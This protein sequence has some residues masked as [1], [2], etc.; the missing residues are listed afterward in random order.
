[1]TL[2]CVYFPYLDCKIPDWIL[3]LCNTTGRHGIQ[4]IPCHDTNIIQTGCAVIMPQGNNKNVQYIVYI[5]NPH[6]FGAITKVNRNVD[7]A[8]V[9][10][11]DAYV[12]WK[13]CF[14]G[15]DVLDKSKAIDSWDYR[16]LEADDCFGEE[17]FCQQ[18]YTVL[19]TRWIRVAD[20]AVS[21]VVERGVITII[22]YIS[23]T[24]GNISADEISVLILYCTIHNQILDT[25]IIMIKKKNNTVTLPELEPDR[26]E[27]NALTIRPPLLL[28]SQS[29]KKKKVRYS[30]TDWHETM[31]KR[32]QSVLARIHIVSPQF[33]AP[34][35]HE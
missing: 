18:D 27:S 19:A 4:R 17:V 3:Y 6:R 22:P 8:S 5:H 25:N 31:S 11:F 7:I 21:S 15:R 12:S 1:M 35:L 26:S 14:Y 13:A 9:S 32:A 16:N 30:P 20:A 28:I 34:K 24:L 29:S 2:W 23:E 10:D 33:S